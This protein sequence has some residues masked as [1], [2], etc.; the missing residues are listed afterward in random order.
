MPLNT[1]M[2]CTGTRI[3]ESQ[4]EELAYF[5]G[6]NSSGCTAYERICDAVIRTVTN[7]EC[8]PY[9]GDFP[10][11][12]IYL[13]G[14]DGLAYSLGDG[15]GGGLDEE[16]VTNIAETVAMTAVNT[17]IS[18]TANRVA[19][20]SGTHAIDDS[21]LLVSGSDLIT[22]ANLKVTG[23]LNVTSIAPDS[24]TALTID[25]GTIGALNIGTGANAK[26]ITIG[27]STS[28]TQLD[29]KAGSGN[30]NIANGNLVVK[31]GNALRLLNG[32]G[33]VGLSAP[34]NPTT[35]ALIL[36]SAQGGSGQTLSNDGSGNLSWL[37]P[38]V[39]ANLALSNLSSVALNT[40]LI[41]ATAG[42]LAIGSAAKPFSS[43]FLGNATTNNIQLTGIATAARVATFPDASGTVQYTNTA[44]TV[45]PTSTLAGLPAAPTQTL[46]YSLTNDN[47][48]LITY[49]LQAAQ[50]VSNNGHVYNVKDFGAKGDC[51]GVTGTDDTAAIQAAVDAS[52]AGAIIFFPTGNYLTTSPINC[53]TPRVFRGDGTSAA[54]GTEYASTITGNYSGYVLN[55]NLGA[56]IG[57]SG[58]ENL[59]VINYHNSAGGGFYLYNGGPT[60]HIRS[61]S[62]QAY[63]CVTLQDNNFT[64]TIEDVHLVGINL[65]NQSGS[66]GIYA[67]P[68]HCNIFS[69]D[70][71]LCENAVRGAGAVS[72]FG[73]RFEVN[74]TGVVL[75]VSSTGGS[76]LAGPVTITGVT[77][78]ACD[79][80]ILVSAANS[81]SIIDCTILGEITPPPLSGNSI[82]AI[83]V[84]ATNIGNISGL[85]V[86][87]DFSSES[88]KIDGPVVFSR[89]S[90]TNGMGTTWNVSVPD[91]CS[92]TSTN[93]QSA[94][95]GEI[96]ARNLWLRGAA[97][98]AATYFKLTG[99]PTGVRTITFQDA[100]G[101][102]ALT[103]D[104]TGYANSALSNLAS[105]SINT[106]LLFQTGVDVGSTTKPAR[107][108]YACGAGTFGTNYFKFTGTPTGA[109]TQTFPDNSG[110]VANLN[111][112]QTWSALQT[113]STSPTSP[114]STGSER[115][116][117]SANVS[118]ATNATAIGNSIII[119]G[120]SSSGIGAGTNGNQDQ[121]TLIGQ[122][123][124][125]TGVGLTLVGQGAGGAGTNGSGLGRAVTVNNQ[126]SIVLG[127]LSADTAA[128]QL[129]AG[130][131]NSSYNIDNVFIGGGV[132]NSSPVATTYNATGGSGTNIAGAALNLAGGK[133]T[134]NALGGVINFQYSTATTSGTT[135][136]SLA[137]IYT[138]DGNGL[139]G[140]AGKNLRLS[141]SSSGVITIAG[142]AAAGTWSLTLPTSGGSVGQLLRTDG[143][144][145]ATWV[146]T[147][148][149]VITFNKALAFD[150]TITT[151]GTTG[152]QTIN[153]PSGTVNIAAAGTSIT[154]TNSLVT[155]SSIV[156]AVVRTN[157]T[158][159]VIKNVVASSGSFVITLNAAAT[160]ETSVGFLVLN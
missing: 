114:G 10:G 127:F 76:Q 100:S 143:S 46:L 99:T 102:V 13:L 131:T 70:I 133:G 91:T 105:V 113:F 89:C 11:D 61:C 103:S 141:G 55:F 62:V 152:D 137:T 7:R 116:G 1:S 158:T 74:Q 151:G 2:P 144:G 130:S 50:W 38:T 153:K 25:S 159:A 93:Y 5:T 97:S 149:D 69:A 65:G 23:S 132:V 34:S 154:V 48:G 71:T 33:F 75:G 109:R 117:A 40:A 128:K 73:G 72:I 110:T 111:L 37:T 64:T 160:A 6:V 53:T 112:A 17:A 123:I 32:T 146:S 80:G 16:S 45:I 24:A 18:G 155:A 60:S 56:I 140:A 29:L 44:N 54:G 98:G 82:N 129:V 41:P 58:L 122:G 59:R 104:L 86:S 68:G 49:N 35:Y 106:S 39:G 28:S 107:D 138:I 121:Q 145:V 12:D 36:P 8:I 14:A 77:F 84:A 135:L 21:P 142:A 26:V 52:A 22:D 78:E 57:G 90:V 51:I 94:T 150:R 81:W 66:W 101:T 125:G 15:F 115:W 156:L 30:V 83:T 95:N 118:T 148:S 47:R 63:R 157:D 27:N 124:T 87:G 9:G 31:G 67:G 120:N 43:Y 19:F 3:K 4:I 126:G 119:S 85:T 136:Q 92:F 20:F 79:K 134:G 139:L 88:L 147:L 108:L 96:Q 42:S